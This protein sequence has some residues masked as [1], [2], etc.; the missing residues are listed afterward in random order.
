MNATDLKDRIHKL[1]IGD[2]RAP[3]K[4]L[5]ILLALGQLQANQAQFLRYSIVKSSLLI[6]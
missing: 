6:C 4:P 2:Q 1:S 3:H 5:L